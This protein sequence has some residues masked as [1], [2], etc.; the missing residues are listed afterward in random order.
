[1]L[2]TPTKLSVS[3]SPPTKIP[4]T[5]FVPGLRT[6]LGATTS[7][8]L[9]I[10]IDRNRL[11][12]SITH[13]LLISRTISRGITPLTWTTPF[14]KSSLWISSSLVE[15]GS[16]LSHLSDEAGMFPVFDS[17]LSRSRCSSGSVRTSNPP[18]GH[19][20]IYSS[21]PRPIRR[22]PVAGEEAMAWLNV[23]SVLDCPDV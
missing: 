3:T 11:L 12:H 22:A 20:R 5:G 15:A 2:S 10:N 8:Y 4:S 9:C 6:P 21:A 16:G 13:L 17:I 19:S 18:H 14:S 7:K 23:G 1:M